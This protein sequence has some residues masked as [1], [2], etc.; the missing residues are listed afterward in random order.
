MFRDSAIQM[1]LVSGLIF[2]GVVLGVEIKPGK[3]G[4]FQ[5]YLAAQVAD[6]R[7]WF[8]SPVVSA[9]IRQVAFV[10][11]AAWGVYTKLALPPL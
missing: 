6:C 3:G 7:A 2:R 1:K 11:G 8:K 5:T 4:D 9:N 10:E